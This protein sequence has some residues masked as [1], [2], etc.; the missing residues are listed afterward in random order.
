[1]RCTSSHW[2][3]SGERRTALRDIL[4]RMDMEEEKCS[5]YLRLSQLYCTISPLIAKGEGG[6][7]NR[8]AG[9]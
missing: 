8:H 1:M 7:S 6:L 4:K 5:L 9:N 3:A 2:N